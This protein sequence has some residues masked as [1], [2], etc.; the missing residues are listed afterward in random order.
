MDRVPILHSRA[1][2][3]FENLDQNYSLGEDGCE[4]DRILILGRK[5]IL[6]HR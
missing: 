2:A 5:F 6:R 1:V 4:A 3:M